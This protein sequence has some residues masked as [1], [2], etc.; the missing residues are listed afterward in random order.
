MISLLYLKCDMIH[1]L[2]EDL[3]ASFVR[4]KSFYRLEKEIFG[5]N[6]F[7]ILFQWWGHKTNKAPGSKQITR[8][9]PKNDIN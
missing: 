5:M 9:F 1:D 2:M 8:V 3:S 6:S 7:H 4:F